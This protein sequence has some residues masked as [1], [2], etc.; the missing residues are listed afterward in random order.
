M[1]NFYSLN[2]ILQG[3]IALVMGAILLAIA[4]YWQFVIGNPIVKILFIFIFVP[5]YSFLLTPLLTLLEYYQYK[6]PMLLVLVDSKKN[7]AI[8]SGT[9]FDYLVKMSNIKS[10]PTFQSKILEYHLEGILKMIEEVENKTIP[11]STIIKG[12]SYFFSESTAR[13]LG[14]KVVKTKNSEKLGIYLDYLE[15]LWMYSVSKGK[16]SFPKLNNFKN[17]ETTG[18]E[19]M[20]KK[21]FIQNLHLRLRKRN[22]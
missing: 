18:K 15:I 6:S 9:S 13:K 19:L 3:T 16:L 4:Y 17:V 11:D 1:T 14:F 21:S 22:G 8:H 12:S 10:G 7:Y 2:K 5:V 20:E